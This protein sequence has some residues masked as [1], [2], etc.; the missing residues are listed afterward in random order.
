[1]NDKDNDSKD[2][3]FVYNNNDLSYY[4]I[5]FAFDKLLG[6]LA[7]ASE[8][9]EFGDKREEYSDILKKV[10]KWSCEYEDKKTLIYIDHKEILSVYSK[11]EELNDDLIANSKSDI[12]DEIVIWLWEIMV[13][14]KKQIDNYNTDK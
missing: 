12:S 10:A 11:L 1:M 4:N 8:Y 14:R 6:P 9:K 2:I 7:T 3:G 13:L 5:R